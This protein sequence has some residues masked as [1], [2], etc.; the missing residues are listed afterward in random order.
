[1]AL[2]NTYKSIYQPGNI[3]DKSLVFAYPFLIDKGLEGKYGEL[4]RDFFAIQFINQI[5]ESS[6]INI[7]TSA[8]SAGGSYTSTGDSLNPAETLARSMGHLQQAP[9]RGRE[10]NYDVIDKRD[11]QDKLYQFQRFI[12]NQVYNDP[13]YADLKPLISSVTVENLLD[14]PLIVGSKSYGIDTNVLFWIMFIATGALS[15]N[16]LASI[17]LCDKQAIERLKNVMFRMDK[18]NYNKFF[19]IEVPT[20][21]KPAAPK[22]A[23]ILDAFPDKFS[24]GLKQFGYAL[25]SDQWKQQISVNPTNSFTVSI[26]NVITDNPQLKANVINNASALFMGLFSNDIIPLL[27]STIHILVADTEIDYNRQINDVTNKANSVARQIFQAIS[28]SI[29]ASFENKNENQLD[30]LFDKQEKMCDINNRIAVSSILEKVK[31]A[32]FS[33]TSNNVDYFRFMETMNVSASQM[34]GYVATLISHISELGTDTGRIDALLKESRDKL[35]ESFKGLLNTVS[36]TTI[37][38]GLIVPVIN[39]RIHS[40]LGTPDY[41]VEIFKQNVVENLTTISQFL[42]LYVYFSYNCEYLEQI[43]AK[44]QVARNTAIQFPNYCLVLPATVVYKVYMAMAIADLKADRD[45]SNTDVSKNFKIT[46]QSIINMVRSLSQKLKIPNII[47]IDEK[48]NSI[49]YRWMFHNP[50]FFAKMSINNLSSYITSQKDI[51]PSI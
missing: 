26:N 8:I 48:T 42:S 38:N 4:L 2:S 39:A 45:M 12:Q 1:M 40:I 49:Y 37:V 19:S 41:N 6:I 33:M 28:D 11:Y 23:R 7:T 20:V 14:V 35:E 31:T 9:D 13:K 10:Y 43:R 44:V 16:T 34:N 25:D 24:H 29:E 17:E 18:N 32:Y 15:P 5:K 47:V 50:G 21:T 51:L 36:P 22:Y 27:H 30:H 46:E 3:N